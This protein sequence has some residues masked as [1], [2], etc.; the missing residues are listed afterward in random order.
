MFRKTTALAVAA[1]ALTAIALP[2][3][4]S[5]FWK[6][7]DTEP[8]QQDKQFGVTGNLAFE[9]KLSGKQA[10]VACTITARLKLTADQTTGLV[11]TLV[12]EPGP[13]GEPKTETERCS[14]AG[15]L[16]FCQFHNLTPQAPNWTFHTA[17]WQTT[18]LVDDQTKALGDHKVAGVI[19]TQDIVLQTGGGGFCPAISK[20]TVTK[21]SVGLI[22]DQDPTVKSL[23]LNGILQAHYQTAG[24]QDTQH[25]EVFGFWNVEGT[26]S[27]TYSF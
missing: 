23:Q 18:Q 19:T 15:W 6:H 20:I 13:S 9:T 4:A 3:S 27:G 21:G 2:A 12:P 22:P 17:T 14:G 1:L 25:V 26:A 10:L 24:G 8:I 7:G 5:A 11:E 16:V